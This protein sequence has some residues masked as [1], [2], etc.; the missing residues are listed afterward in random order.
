MKQIKPIEEK[1]IVSKPLATPNYQGALDRTAEHYQLMVKFV[2]QQM[3]ENIDYGTIP[4]T[5]KPT[6]FKA[7]A[8]KLCR[9]FNLRPTFEIVDSIVNFEKPLF[10][11]HYRCSLYRSGELVANADGICNSYEARYKKQQYKTFDLV[12]TI[13][14]M[15]QKRALVASVLASCGA[16]EF[17]TQDLE[18][19]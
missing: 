6:L 15:S 2:K 3:I 13:C 12:N 8:E 16:S 7:G 9:L 11:Y 10:H 4:G 5:K 17:F 19:N 18:N 14:K 1:E